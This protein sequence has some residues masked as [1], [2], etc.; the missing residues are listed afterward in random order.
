MFA[1][2]EI[3][4]AQAAHKGFEAAQVWVADSVALGKSASLFPSLDDCLPVKT[5]DATQFLEIMQGGGYKFEPK[6]LFNNYLIPHLELDEKERIVKN[7]ASVQTVAQS[8]QTG[9]YLKDA[10]EQLAKDVLDAKTT[11]SVAINTLT[12]ISKIDITN[13]HMVTRTV[14]STANAAEATTK[15]AT[16]VIGRLSSDVKEIGRLLGA[17]P[18][19]HLPTGAELP[20]IV[21][22]VQHKFGS[23]LSQVQKALSFLENLNFLPHFKVSMTNEWGMVMSTSMNRDDLLDKIPSGTRDA[24][25]RIIERFE[26]IITSTISLS[27]FLFKMHIGTTIKIPT[28]VGPIVALGTGAFDVAL[29]TSGVQVGLDLGFGIGV[30]FTVGPFSASAS[31]TQSQTILVTEAAFGLGISACMRAH[32]NLVIASADLYLE[33]KLLVVGGVCKVHQAEQHNETTIW[34]YASVKIAFHVS[35]FLVCNIGVEEEAHWDSN[36]NGGHCALDQM[37]DLRH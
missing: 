29:G 30:D 33:A 20:T 8:I 21:G 27:A 12:N 24:V 22:E 5:G 19:L 10:G 1:N 32:V 11:L 16:R 28:G 23:A 25:E 34:A 4:F 3:P 14:A 15:D 2:P 17:D 7:D 37:S 26:F 13:L 9:I 36:M 18:D 35:I 31:Y 6:R